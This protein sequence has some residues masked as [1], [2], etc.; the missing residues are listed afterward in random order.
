ISV[1][2]DSQAE[3]VNIDVQQSPVVL[4][5]GRVITGMGAVPLSSGDV[6]LQRTDATGEPPM[7]ATTSGQTFRF[8]AVGPGDYVLIARCRP[9]A[10]DPRE[11]IAARPLSIAGA[12]VMDL[13]LFLHAA[14]T[15]DGRLTVNSIR[16]PTAPLAVIL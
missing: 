12:D 14:P 2:A 3:N 11:L 7:A 4:V 9:R 8:R 1:T 10:G 6:I 16:P 5:D 13:D 15:L